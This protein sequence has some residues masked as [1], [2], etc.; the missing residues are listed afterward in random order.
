MCGTLQHEECLA[1]MRW[2]R[3]K[4]RAGR[5]RSGKG[6][7]TRRDFDLF[8]S[9]GILRGALSSHRFGEG[10]CRVNTGGVGRHARH[11]ARRSAEPGTKLGALVEN[12]HFA[13]VEGFVEKGR[14]EG[15][16]LVL[17]GDR[18]NSNLGE[19]YLSPTIFD[20]VTSGMT[21]AREEIFGSALSTITVNSD[22]EAVA[23]ANDTDY[24]LGATLWGSG[25]ARVHT[26]ARSLRA[27]T[28]W[29]NSHDHS[30]ITVPFGGYK[31]S[32]NGRDKFL[33]A[34]D[35]YF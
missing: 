20:G 27:R 2:Q 35:K 14:E 28:V 17:G 8:W 7:G 11:R 12:D 34:F 10:S 32:G 30:D 24:G 9:W 16:K 23:V 15:A 18:P 1:G 6:W 13:R 33:H 4:Y 5:C 29:V 26:F 22:E 25:I 21:I 31:Q 3:A 19:Y